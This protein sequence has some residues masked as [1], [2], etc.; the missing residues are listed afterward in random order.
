MAW[1]TFL[2]TL[3]E[4]AYEWEDPV[5]ILQAYEEMGPLNF[6]NAID[7]PLWAEV[8]NHTIDKID[9]EDAIDSATLIAGHN[10]VNWKELKW[11]IK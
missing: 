9:L 7:L 8:Q 2:H 10:P 11:E 1:V 6:I 3:H 5:E 4:A